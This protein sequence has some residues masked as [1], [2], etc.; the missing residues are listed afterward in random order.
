[1][2]W[3]LLAIVSFFVVAA[4]LFPLRLQKPV[5]RGLVCIVLVVPLLAIALY[6]YLGRPDVL[7]HLSHTPVPSKTFQSALV[8]LSTDLQHNPFDG[9]GWIL[10]ARSYMRIGQQQE[11]LTTWKKA[12]EYF[13]K[14]SEILLG[15]GQALVFKSQGF[16]SAEAQRVFQALLQQLPKHPQARF[17]LALVQAQNGDTDS[18]IHQWS[19]ILATSPHNAPWRPMIQHHLQQVLAEQGQTLPQDLLPPSQLPSISQSPTPQTE[20]ERQELIQSMVL[21]LE[22]RL[23]DTP[24]DI[25]GWLFLAHSYFVL[26]DPD[27]QEHALLKAFEHQPEDINVL[28]A[29]GNFLIQTTPLEKPL[30]PLLILIMTRI[31]SLKPYHPEALWILGLNA[32]HQG[33]IEETKNLWSKALLQLDPLSVAYTEIEDA[34]QSLD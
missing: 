6:V 25:Q 22:K 30:P 8:R 10:L 34:L 2:F 16:V 1:M 13:P 31:A 21:R 9:D 11:S 17:F 12:L 14:N 24:Q 18:A 19:D 4:L 29:Y 26:K 3:I 15:L 28:I 32:N 33:R 20:Q 23:Q 27:K 5:P 7:F